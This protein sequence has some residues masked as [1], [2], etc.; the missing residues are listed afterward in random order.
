MDDIYFVSLAVPAEPVAHEHYTESTQNPD[1]PL[2]CDRLT[3]IE[4][5][6]KA[7]GPKYTVSGSLGP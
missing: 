2:F 3:C 7:P 1:A 6:S 4:F 5:H